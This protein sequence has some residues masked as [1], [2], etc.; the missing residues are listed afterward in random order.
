MK[1][2]NSKSLLE[3]IGVRVI[4]QKTPTLKYT[5]S[6]RSSANSQIIWQL[7]L[8]FVHYNIIHNLPHWLWKSFQGP[9]QF[10]KSKHYKNLYLTIGFAIFSDDL[11]TGSSLIVLRAKICTNSSNLILRVVS[12]IFSDDL[13]IVFQTKIHHH[14]LHHHRT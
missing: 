13:T 5:S 11:T 9:N 3:M 4:L 1:F 6:G 7:A 10:S 2:S 14:R 12:A 8:H